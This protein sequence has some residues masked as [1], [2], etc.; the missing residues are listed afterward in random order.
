MLES[1]TK[2]MVRIP[3]ESQ[4]ESRRITKINRGKFK[5]LF[6]ILLKISV[7]QGIS[8]IYGFFDVKLLSY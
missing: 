8:I 4:S 7:I 2:N 3:S 6:P 1:I 5:R